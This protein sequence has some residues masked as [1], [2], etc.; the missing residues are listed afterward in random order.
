ME[1][2]L[3]KVK[4]RS[5]ADKAKIR[6]TEEKQRKE[7]ALFWEEFMKAFRFQFIEHR[8]L[9]ERPTTMISFTPDPMYRPNEVV[10]TKYLPKVRGQIW[11]D[12]ADEEIAHIE[13]EFM[14]DVT[15]GFGLLGRVSA[16]TRYSMD[17]GKQIG[18]QWLPVKA[19]TVIKMRQLLVMK[20][21]QK[22]TYEYGNYRKFSTEVRFNLR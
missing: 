21:D 5:E 7:R 9:Q 6:A 17:L 3:A 1:E 19:E 13:L 4:R 12:D 16:G 15:A 10:D 2:T 11:I 18:D 22:Y 20:T 14:N 8:K